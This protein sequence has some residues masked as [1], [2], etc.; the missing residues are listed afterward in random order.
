MKFH[1]KIPALYTK[2]C[3]IFAYNVGS[4][5]ATTSSDIDS[6]SNCIT[7]TIHNP[8]TTLSTCSTCCMQVVGNESIES[9]GIGK[10]IITVESSR[11]NQSHLRHLHPILLV[12]QCTVIHTYGTLITCSLPSC[13][14]CAQVLTATVPLDNKDRACR[15]HYILRWVILNW[16]SSVTLHRELLS[17]FWPCVPTVL[18]MG[19]SFIGI[20]EDSWWVWNDACIRDTIMVVRVVWCFSSL[21]YSPLFYNKIQGGDTSEKSGVKG[22]ESVWGPTAFPDEFH[23]DNTHDKV[24][25]CTSCGPVLFVF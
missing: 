19:Q 2:A 1:S 16:R 6:F 24:L 10:K 22:G 5:P 25:L 8:A 3:N 20:S 21:T 12:I 17:T 13:C 14:H 18:M 11:M 9:I 4:P 15:W 23:P 7:C